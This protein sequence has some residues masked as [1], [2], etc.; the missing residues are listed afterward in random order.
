MSGPTTGPTVGSHDPI[1]VTDVTE[2]ICNIAAVAAAVLDIH[3]RASQFRPAAEARDLP[4]AVMSASVV[5]AV[6]LKLLHYLLVQQSWQML[7][8]T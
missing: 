6:S 1:A 4:A 5:D 3:A 2:C 8:L 7:Q